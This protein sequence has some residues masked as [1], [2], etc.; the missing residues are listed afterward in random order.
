MDE[1]WPI[2]LILKYLFL[3]TNTSLSPTTLYIWH[4]HSMYSYILHRDKNTH[5]R[6]EVSKLGH[7][8]SGNGL[9]PIRRQAV[10]WFNAEN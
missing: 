3:D 2:S 9:L 1:W 8:W 5:E 10:T 6:A 7:P 4:L